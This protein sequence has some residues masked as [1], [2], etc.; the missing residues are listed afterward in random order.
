M[1]HITIV[2][3]DEQFNSRKNLRALLDAEPDLRVVG[4]VNNGLDALDMVGNL[5]PDVLIFN[6]NASNNKEIIQ[7][8]ELRCPNM[9]IVVPNKFGKENRGQELLRAGVKAFILKNTTTAELLEAIRYV[10]SKK[11]NLS[12]SYTGPALRS[13]PQNITGY[14]HDPI[15]ILTPRELEVYNLIFEEMTNAQ[16]ATQLSISRRTVEVHRASIVRKLGLR[17]LRQQLLNYAKQRNMGDW[18]ITNL[19][20]EKVDPNLSS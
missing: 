7:L 5:N 14:V 16:I 13:Q 3:A 10:N 8:M 2:L 20:K 15:A 11:T 12:A 1:K 17:N 19:M 18:P 4:E 6:L 9:A